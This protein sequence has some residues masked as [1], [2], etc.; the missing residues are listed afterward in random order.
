MAKKR[1]CS[2]D[3]CPKK[4]KARAWCAMHY[5]RWRRCGDPLGGFHCIR[6]DDVRRFWSKVDKCGPL[7]LW[8]PFL[9]RCW[10]WTGAPTNQGYGHL[11][12]RGLWVKAHRLA[13]EMLVGPVP[14][15][16]ELDHLCRVRLCVR[17]SHLE[18]VTHAE[19]VARAPSRRAG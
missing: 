13:Y 11:K 2:I 4:V 15:G 12:I 9:G 18:P 6:G 10:L 19:N 8:A 1:T 14:D 3:G 5:D 16:L 17:P 7:P